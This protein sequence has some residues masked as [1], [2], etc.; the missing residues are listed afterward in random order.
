VTALSPLRE[1]RITGS[2]IAAVLGASPYGTRDSVMRDMVRGH[3][4]DA[5]EFA[6]NIATE[7][8]D[9]HEARAIV[10]YELA[11]G[12]AVYA[13]QQFVIHPVYPFLGV[14]PDGLV[15]DDGMVEVKCPYRAAYSHIS[16]RPDYEAQIRLQLACTGR[17]WCDFVVWRPDGMSVS[18]VL[19]DPWWLESVL[20]ELTG[21]MSEYEA[22]IAD[23]DL[24]APL[25]APLVD[26]RTDPD[27]R[28]ASLD[29]LDALAVQR[30][31][32]TV[33]ADARA[34]VLELADGKAT[35]GAGVLVTRSERAGTV[36]WKAALGKYVPDA[37]VEPY[38]KPSQTVM[39]VRQ[40]A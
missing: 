11:H 31:A 21:F 25:R 5:T 22:T 26:E 3:F 16:Q 14:S 10:E 9:E 13:A 2:R 23:P 29:Y 27:W 28:V 37:D 34:R 24:A 4:G 35:R 18:R 40:S 38:R 6:G 7:W 15:G 30:A 20:P 32:E 8:G 1:G 19:D 12:G 17:Q 33:T 39:S 36:D